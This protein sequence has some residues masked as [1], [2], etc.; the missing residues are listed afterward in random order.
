[1]FTFLL[2]LWSTACL[3]PWFSDSSGDQLLSCG[4]YHFSSLCHSRFS[5]VSSNRRKNHAPTGYLKGMST[6]I[7]SP[8]WWPRSTQPRSSAMC[9]CKLVPSHLSAGTCSVGR[10]EM[11]V[12]PKR[13]KH[14]QS[15]FEQIRNSNKLKERKTIVSTVY[16]YTNLCKLKINKCKA[17]TARFLYPVSMQAMMYIVW[18]FSPPTY[19]FAS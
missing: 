17:T 5:I 19:L 2:P 13:K 14:S 16:I 8:R 7:S 18:G 12:N 6:L 9:M 10:G 3:K 11:Q 1:M 15:I 4:R